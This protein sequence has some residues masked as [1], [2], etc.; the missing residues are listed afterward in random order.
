[1]RRV[2]LLLLF[3]PL[4]ACTDGVEAPG[5]TLDFGE[6]F[7][8]SVAVE[9]SVPIV[10]NSNR[11]ETVT[12]V[13][14]A[15]GTAFDFVAPAVPI[16]LDAGAPYAFT[17]AFQP[18]TDGYQEW[19]DTATLTIEAGNTTYQ[20]TV[21][22]RGL[23]T[24]GDLDG[25][26]HV[27]AALGCPTCDDCDDN[28]A[29]VFPGNE[30][31]C[32]G[33]DNNCDG[34]IGALE[35][36]NDGDNFLICDGDCNDNSVAQNPSINEICDGLDNDCD[37]SLS[38]M[39]LDGDGDGITECAGD[40]EPTVAAVN[41]N[42]AEVCDGYDTDCS[43]GGAIPPDELDGDND[44]YRECSGECD[45][46]NAAANPG[47][48]QEL[49]DGF[50]TDCDGDELPDEDDVDGD[51]FFPCNGD[52]DDGQPL[53][54]PGNPEVCDFID[55]DC[56]GVVPAN[57]VD[58]D[59][60]LSPDCVDCDDAD[61]TVY[62]AAPD[63][64]DGILDNDCDGATDP[65]ESD[66]D[67]DG[68]TECVGDCDDGDAAINTAAAEICDGL[69]NDCSGSPL[70]SETFD[71][72]G[73]GTLDCTD[74]DCPIWVD[75]S[76]GGGASVG[77]QADPYTT[78]ADG[79]TE[80]GLTG[81]VT[82]AVLPGSYDGQV[83]FGSNVDLRLVAEQG[84]DVTTLDGDG[85]GPVVVIAGGQTNDALLQGFTITGGESLITD[86]TY[87]GHGGGI[88]VNAAPTIQGNII[89]DNQAD[90]HGGGLYSEAGDVV[91]LENEFL[92]NVADFDGGGA[93]VKAS[94]GLVEGNVFVG[95]EADDDAG[96]L[97]LGDGSQAEVR[98]NVFAMNECTGQ[99]D[100][101]GNGWG[102]GYLNHAGADLEFHNN[103][104][105]G[106]IAEEGGGMFVFDSAPTVEN[107]T[108][109]DNHSTT[110]GEAAGIRI[111]QGE[112]ANNVVA[113]GTG[114]GVRIVGNGAGVTWEYN[115]VW[116]FP[117][118][119]YYD[120]P[121]ESADGDLTGTDGN[122]SVNPLFVTASQD[123][124]WNDDFTLQPASLLVDAGDPNALVT[125]PDGSRSDIGAFGGPDG[126]WTAPQP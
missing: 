76:Y 99:N 35:V 108:F 5:T 64:C 20:V 101:S 110:I 112:F 17:F 41:P 104:V 83:D 47:Q 57:E 96:G 9:D 71:S 72:D 82:V 8:N 124:V 120:D 75:N 50:D 29:A 111:F 2:A 25:D 65:N 21:P 63:V 77:T 61:P 66:D 10:N 43:N 94:D 86:P 91:L 56:D 106:N 78:I 81:C 28:N 92:G 97:F 38:A 116:D 125:D 53:S 48:P 13:A 1:M 87:T 80:A 42:A 118:G 79:I 126:D 18:P 37:G 14:W 51:G 40:C 26:G 58:G 95:N 32:D 23:Y 31:L 54:F 46:A 3:V 85:V 22:V 117:D 45:D 39:E 107:N 69:D 90:F 44:G 12:S 73:D 121:N 27:D 89:E 34:N 19:T 109:Y 102:G 70:A 24:N 114:V 123:M 74:S 49:C 115:A 11:K 67:G 105:V 119:L 122:I 16:E 55:N 33:L 36:D 113:G 98:W 52:C 60:D 6:I 93:Y 103:I 62:P 84:P 4:L 88:Y 100:A 68:E 15:T 30:E 59:G 7:D